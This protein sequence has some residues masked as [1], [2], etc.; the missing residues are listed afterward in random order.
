MIILVSSVIGNSQG[1]HCLN[2]FQLTRSVLKDSNLHRVGLADS[3]SLS[4]HSEA[5]EIGNGK[6]APA[7]GEPR[8][9]SV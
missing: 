7:S 8:H 2:S 6:M 5:L 1:Q 3:K 4:D 9:Y